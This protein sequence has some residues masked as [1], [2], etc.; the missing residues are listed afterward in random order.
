MPESTAHLLSQAILAAGGTVPNAVA[1][2][3]RI[4]QP[5]EA[6]FATADTVEHDPVRAIGLGTAGTPPSEIAFLDGVQ[7]YGV[8]GRFGLVPVV[9][10][11]VAAA[12]LA[13]QGQELVAQFVGG[14]EFIVVPV[15]RLPGEG[16]T[17][18]EQT[19]LTLLDS[20]AGDRPHPIADVYFAAR[21]VESRREAV[22]L[23]VGGKYLEKDRGGWL[24]VDGS[25][26]GYDW[27]DNRTQLLGVVKS[28]E[29]QFLQGLD[30]ETALTLPSQ[31]RTSV[32]AR[33]VRGRR[34]VYTWYLRLWPPEGH[35]LLHG[36]V[37]LE[38]PAA[39]GVVE[40]ATAVSR[41]LL[42]E[43]APIAAPDERWDRL[44]YPIRQVE[45]YLRARAGGWT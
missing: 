3:S 18:L 1:A 28:H 36:L 14:E 44:L 6:P 17:V 39:D 11:R 26:S 10:G 40:E 15:D 12:V 33:R 13:R 29:T 32:F 25:L 37:R 20:R 5:V 41:W 7:W 30:L 42:A 43:R 22:E 8:A 9:R 38:R 23:D 2:H 16:I 21:V 19:G 34:R 27:V 31:H 4:P 45:E 24:V 35:D